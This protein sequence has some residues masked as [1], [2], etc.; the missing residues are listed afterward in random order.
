MYR[1]RSCRRFVMFWRR[2]LPHVS[3]EGLRVFLTWRVAGSIPASRPANSHNDPNPGKAF[4]EFDR[5]LDRTRLGPRWLADTNVA[6]M[7]VE[8]LNYGADVRQSYDLG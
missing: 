2:R 6:N 5:V 7:F 4:A 1:R 8:A 3:P